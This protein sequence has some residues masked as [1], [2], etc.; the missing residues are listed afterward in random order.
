MQNHDSGYSCGYYICDCGEYY[1]QQSCGV[2]T[3]ITYCANC[4][5]K[6][7][8]LNQKLIK[9]E[10]DNGVYKIMRIYPDEK[11]KTSVEARDDLKSIYGNKFENGYPY[12][13]FIDFEK[14]MKTEMNKDYKGIL[15]Q[16]Y[17]LFIKE[18]KSIRNIKNQITYRLLSFIIYANIYFSFK[19]GYL[20][21]NDINKNNYIP[22]EEKPYEGPYSIDDSY[23]DY[24]ANL[25]NNRKNGISD[26]KFI[27]EILR[28]N[29]VLLEKQLKEK[30]I[31]NIQ[32]FIN[33][34]INDLFN[35]MKNCNEM[36]TPEQRNIFESNFEDF[37]N[38]SIKNYEKNSKEYIKNIDNMKDINVEIE[39]KIL[40][41]DSMLSSIEDIFPYYYEFLSIPLVKE[42]DIKDLLKSIENAEKKYPVLCSYLNI[43]KR[44]MECLQ[45]FS[46]INNFVNYTI[47]HYSNAISREEARNKK[48]IEEIKN[49]NIPTNLFNEFL[50]A[51]ND[52]KLYEISNQFD[53]HAFKFVL[54]KFSKDDPLS[55]FLIDNGVQSY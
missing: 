35:L 8:G 55:N 23:N 33:T 27:I 34:I 53:C 20:S 5:K 41:T 7:G 47:E 29:W 21:L 4:H 37:I 30:N 32:I 14:R 2:P 28:L 6:I 18:T 45:T 38:S 44:H 17:L 1:F 10:E 12:E 50:K 3:D 22:I 54:R 13:L 15:E 31:N 48:I 24:R 40:E 49:K 39:Y 26:E 25:L 19:C 51:F 46:Q 16:N 11:N 36:S 9:R 42:N 52:N 43:N